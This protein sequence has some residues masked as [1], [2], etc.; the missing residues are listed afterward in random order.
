[1]VAKG[2]VFNQNDKVSSTSLPFAT[3][4]MINVI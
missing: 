4:F 1:M 2:S 3:I